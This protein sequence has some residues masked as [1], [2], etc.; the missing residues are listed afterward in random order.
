[1]NTT[2]ARLLLK[3][4]LNQNIKTLFGV[5]G[6]SY[7]SILDALND[8]PEI[9]WIGAR[10]EGGASFMA[11]GFAQLTGK[12]GICFVTRAPG[13]TNASIGIHTAFQGSIPL[14]LFIGQ[15][16]LTVKGREAFQELDYKEMFSGMAK[17]VTEVNEVNRIPEIMARA[18]NVANSGR[19]GP[20]IVSLPEDV[21]SSICNF[22]PIP[23]ILFPEPSVS[24][25]DLMEIKEKLNNADKPIVIVGGTGWSDEGKKNFKNFVEKNNLPVIS[26]FRRQDIFDNNSKSYVG[27]SSFGNSKYL[28]QAL[29]EAD[30]IFAFNAL[31]GD[32]T[33]NNYK[34]W[35]VPNTHKFLIHSHPEA[36]ELGKVYHS[37]LPVNSGPN[38]LAIELN[39]L[40]KISDFSSYTNNL[41]TEHIKSLSVKDQPGFVDMGKI[42]CYLQSIL[43][44]D[45]IFTNGAGNFSIWSNLL[46]KFG[47]KARLIAPTSG[48]MGFGLPSA[49]AAKLSDPEKTVICFTGDGDF[50]MNLTE[51]G[52]AKQYNAFPI[53]LLLNNS[54][55]GTIR[56]HQEKNY[57][58]RVKA[59]EIINPDYM[60]L[61]E[62]YGMK[63]F[64][65]KRTEEFKN[66]FE[67]LLSSK[68]GGLIE[69]IVDVESITP[70]KTLKE[71]KGF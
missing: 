21:I 51:L 42:I 32:V 11:A 45:V 13:A 52:T 56:M 2:G 8:F 1:M 57:P 29:E 3:C 55:Y 47:E 19:P 33:T 53:I 30:L 18:F 64:Q 34:L 4:I 63:S 28:N 65:V 49:I 16:S 38:N 44:E 50:Q 54:S 22:N 17:W 24:R 7:L 15:V 10:Q 9:N 40:G 41:R 68:N 12:T 39:K 69:L 6:E 58:G 27:V 62:S 26:S 35:S 23:R 31:L 14:I 60:K 5:P 67:K 36:I 59:T 66:I 20:V 70:H 25:Q 46:Y 48:A 61:A 37:N 43:P 71:F